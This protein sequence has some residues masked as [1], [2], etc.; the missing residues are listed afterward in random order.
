MSICS[1]CKIIKLACD[2]KIHKGRQTKQCINCIKSKEVYRLANVNTLHSKLLMKIGNYKHADKVRNRMTDVDIEYLKSIFS[3]ICHYCRK[4][5]GNLN[6]FDRI[7]NN[8]GHIKGNLIP[9]CRS[10]NSQ[11]R[12]KPYEQF[13]KQKTLLCITS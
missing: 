13:V 9:C 8:L 3:P 2:F 10:C 1:N 4:D 11:K 6:G 5:R 12:T 7:D